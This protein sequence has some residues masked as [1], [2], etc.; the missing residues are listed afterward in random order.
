MKTKD[1]EYVFAL[2]PIHGIV[3]KCIDYYDDNNLI[4]MKIPGGQWIKISSLKES[5]YGLINTGSSH[6]SG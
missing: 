6:T 1:D 5:E 4:E 3:V 2:V